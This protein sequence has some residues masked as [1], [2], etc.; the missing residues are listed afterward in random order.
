MPDMKKLA[1]DLDS[2][3]TGF[4]EVDVVFRGN[5][6]VRLML[7]RDNLY[8]EGFFSSSANKWFR[9]KE[10]AWPAT[11]AC[12]TL[13]MS[14]H[15]SQIGT[16]H[17]TISASTIASIGSLN[18]HTGGTITPD[19]YLGLRHLTVGISESLRFA[20]VVTYMMS[21]L[22]YG[23]T[24]DVGSQKELITNW[25]TGSRRGDLGILLPHTKP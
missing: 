7:N 24:F 21:V 16:L 8:V 2:N 10:Q 25:Q 5:S 17:F 12:D 23:R 22:N 6:P 19:I 20:T 13:P 9:F 4:I 14:G 3:R 18:K 1:L 15:Y 11:V